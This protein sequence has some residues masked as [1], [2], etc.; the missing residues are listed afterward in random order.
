MMR[1]T[2][3]GT[4]NQELF[5]ECDAR[6]YTVIEELFN[7]EEGEEFE[8]D[9]IDLEKEDDP[10]SNTK[11]LIYIGN[12]LKYLFTDMKSLDNDGLGMFYDD[13]KK[14]MY[15]ADLAD[16]GI[17]EKEVWIS[18]CQNLI[19][20]M[21]TWKRDYNKL[22]EGHMN[23]EIEGWVWLEAYP[24]TQRHVSAFFVPEQ[25][26]RALFSD[27]DCDLLLS[28]HAGSNS[29]ELIEFGGKIVFERFLPGCYYEISRYCSKPDDEEVR[30]LA[31]YRV[32]LK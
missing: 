1:F 7:L 15:G 25:E 27:S 11:E 26:V 3:Y 23:Y 4:N 19:R 5:A 16:G 18:T 2:I 30:S 21:A 31:Q 14:S 22:L 13:Y 29:F 12:A 20:K 24:L 9:Y 17:D 10:N 32:G 6:N 8:I 28:G